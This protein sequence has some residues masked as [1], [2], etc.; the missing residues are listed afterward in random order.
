MPLQA[1]EIALGK[2]ARISEAQKYMLLTVLGASVVLGITLA[3]V[4]HLLQQLNFNNKIL[5]E[6]DSAIRNYTTAI[7]T[8]GLCTKPSGETYSD[9][10]LKKCD[11]S[12][13]QISQIP[14]TLK[15]KVL[16]ELAANEDLNSV[17]KEASSSCIN[18]KSDDGKA[19]TY[20][21]LSDGLEKATKSGNKEE[22]EKATALMQNCSALRIIPDALPSFRN[23][24]ALL[25]SLNK[26]FIDSGWQPESLSP[27]GTSTS[28]GLQKGLNA[29]S[30][31]LTVE[32][33]SETTMNVLHNI[34]RSIREFNIR[35]AT[36]EW[37]SENSLSLQA[38][39]TAYYVNESSILQTS[40]IIKPGD[41]KK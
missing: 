24:E 29:L 30:V 21:E 31:S 12:T 7:Q 28:T 38:S 20:K 25:A 35:N 10:D 11:P 8:T 4:V 6:Q 27:G 36:I 9:D 18:P 23:E 40:K 19:Y 33:D 1:K 26:L 2:R 14:N 15:S 37:G 5:G 22:I 13:I 39:A 17:P 16:T 3:L 34:E 32:A 41:D